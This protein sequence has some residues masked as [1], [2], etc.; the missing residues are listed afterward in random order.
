M[1]GIRL[2][3][4]ALTMAGVVACL[5][6]AGCGDDE[7]SA[8]GSSG[9]SSAPARLLSDMVSDISKAK[10]RKDCKDVAEANLR[11]TYVM[12]CPPVTPEQRKSVQSIKLL[13]AERFGN[14]A[15]R[16]AGS[17]CR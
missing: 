14:A 15:H 11:A 7:S 6:A 5:A 16:P 8:D 1:E 17:Q 13:R 12:V 4:V 10:T 3:M 9:L 2:Q